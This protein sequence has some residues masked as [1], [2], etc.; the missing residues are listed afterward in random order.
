MDQTSYTKLA[1]KSL[2]NS[3]LWFVEICSIHLHDLSSAYGILCPYGWARIRVS[4]Y[5]SPRWRGC[6]W[7]LCWNAFRNAFCGRLPPLS[8]WDILN[9]LRS[10]ARVCLINHFSSLSG[11][12]KLSNIGL[13]SWLRDVRSSERII[14]N[15]G[16]KS[17]KPQRPIK[18]HTDPSQSLMLQCVLCQSHQCWA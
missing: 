11:W 6:P 18:T 9:R 2:N 8:A 5:Q 12:I 15:L 10:V 4:P 16:I 7:V 13:S 1:G 3:T 17:V 14:S